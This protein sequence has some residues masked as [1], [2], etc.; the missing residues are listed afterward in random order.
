MNKKAYII[1]RWGGTPQS[2]WYPWI[3]NELELLG[4]EVFVPE[5]PNTD[6]PVIE[7][8]VSFLQNLIMVPDEHTLFIGHS[9]GCQTI[10]RF[11]E[12][13]PIGAKVAKVVFVAGW[14]NLDNL[15]DKET[16]DLAKPWIEHSINF[17]KVGKI[18]SNIQVFLSSNDTYGFVNENK[19]IFINELNA[20]VDILENRGHFTE[21][22]GVKELPEILTL[23][24]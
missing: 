7:E 3:K 12:T 15:E 21:E 23:L 4:Y 20:K 2:D 16:Q 13:L 1:H 19:N 24:K 10:M 9:I 8:R 14:F 11:F 22:D 17:A 5:M 18:C 6:H